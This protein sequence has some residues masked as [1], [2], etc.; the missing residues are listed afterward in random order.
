MAEGFGVEDRGR[1]YD[2]VGGPPRRGRHHF[3][4]LLAAA[5][6]EAPRKGESLNAARHR[7][8]ESVVAADSAGYVRGQYNGYRA[9]P[10]VRARSPTETYAALELRVDN[11]RWHGVPFY[12]RAGKQLPITQ[13][14]LR[15]VFDAPPLRG[16]GGG[17]THQGR[18]GA[19]AASASRCCT[20]RREGSHRGRP[21][22]RGYGSSPDVSRSVSNSTWTFRPGGLAGVTVAALE[23]VAAPNGRRRPLLD[24]LSRG[25]RL[26]P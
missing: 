11:E 22:S 23:A 26:S 19:D 21:T 20:P 9:T 2:A 15:L 13:T 4:Q 24:S 12:I 18:D 5:A 16:Q 25:Y 8:F 10:G 17:G 1:F 6:M 14:E 3:L 7:L